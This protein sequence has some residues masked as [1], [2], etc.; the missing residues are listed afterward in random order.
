MIRRRTHRR[1]MQRPRNDRYVEDGTVRTKNP[2]LT[3][4]HLSSLRFI[5]ANHERRDGFLQCDDRAVGVDEESISSFLLL[6][7]VRKAISCGLK[8][9]IL[10]LRIRRALSLVRASRVYAEMSSSTKQAPSVSPQIQYPHLPI[11]LHTTVIFMCSS[12]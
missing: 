8:R 1:Q 9:C 2:Y 12:F 10:H 4:N 6:S 7:P 3:S 11:L 5:R